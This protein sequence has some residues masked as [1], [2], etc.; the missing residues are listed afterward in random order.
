MVRRKARGRRAIP[1][2]LVLRLAGPSRVP[3]LATIDNAVGPVA[4]VTRDTLW[5]AL[6]EVAAAHDVNQRV[7]NQHCDQ[8]PSG[9]APPHGLRVAGE[10]GLIGAAKD[11]AARGYAQNPPFSARE[12]HRVGTLVWR[13]LQPAWAGCCIIVRSPPEVVRVG[14][15]APD[16]ARVK[17]PWQLPAVGPAAQL[18]AC[19]P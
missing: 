1:E 14:L 7:R 9:S 8:S 13:V 3:A 2:Q 15:P 19:R 17:S 4:A 11:L 16:A 18:L 12:T 10:R 6:D 5:L